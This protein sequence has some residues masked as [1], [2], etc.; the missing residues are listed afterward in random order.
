M[1]YMLMFVGTEDDWERFDPKERAKAYEQ[2]GKWWGEH[3]AAGR[4]DDLQDHE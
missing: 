2:I 4:P 1:K 3:A